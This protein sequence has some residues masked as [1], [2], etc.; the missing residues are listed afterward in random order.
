MSLRNLRK[1]LIICKNLE[2]KMERCPKCNDFDY[3][4]VYNG[5]KTKMSCLRCGH[6]Q[7]EDG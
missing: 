5:D 6:E 3:I 1:K 2:N 7:Y 4:T